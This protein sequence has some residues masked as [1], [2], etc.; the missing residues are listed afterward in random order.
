M[1][2]WIIC[3]LR[4]FDIMEKFTTT[5][6][7]TNLINNNGTRLSSLLEFNTAIWQ[8]NNFLFSQELLPVV[9]IHLYI[10]VIFNCYPLDNAYLP[11][12]NMNVVH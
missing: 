1:Y 12:V 5:K 7:Q 6:N 8:V 4:R 10:Y 2:I 9:L 3:L 11:G